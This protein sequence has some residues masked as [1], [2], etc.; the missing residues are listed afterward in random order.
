MAING[1]GGIVL[2]AFAVCVLAVAL[3]LL[4]PHILSSA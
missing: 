3:V 4:L 1:L 2:T